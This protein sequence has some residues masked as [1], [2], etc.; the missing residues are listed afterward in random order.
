[1]ASPLH[2]G[3]DLGTTN[4][5]ALVIDERGRSRGEGAC[6]IHL[7]PVGD[8][9]VEQDLEEIWQ[10]TLTAIRAALATVDPRAVAALGIS[11][12]GGAL[13]LLT[14]DQQPLGRVISWLD[15]RG[16]HDDE[17]LTAA[18]GRPWFRERIVHGRCALAPGQLLRLRRERPEWLTPPHRVG[19]VGDAI[20]GRLCGRA[21]HDA[22]S[23]GL[24]LLLNPRR[25]GYDPDLLDQLGLTPEQ[26]P[27]LLPATERAGGLSASVA[28]A[29][30]LRAGLPVSP[31][32]HD[33]YAS[34]LSTGAVE[35]GV[36]MVGA[37]TAWV[38]LA[39]SRGLPP[40][41]MDDAFVCTHVVPGLGGEILSLVNG[42]SALTWVLGLLGRGQ[43]TPAEIEQLLAA[44]PAGCDGLRCWPFLTPFGASGLAPGTRGRFV[45]LQLGHTPAHL[46]RAV[47]EGLACE[48]AR[49]LQFLERAGIPAQ[50]LVLGGT[51]AASPTTTRIIADVTAL[52]LG[53]SGPGGGSVL[54]A[55]ILARALTEP[56]AALADL[57]R[58][59]QPPVRWVNPGPQADAYRAQLERY[60]ATL[61]REIAPAATPMS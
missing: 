44:A 41:V 49:H 2:L 28:A 50:R 6:G 30:G 57:S 26:L 11:S 18:L 15:Q 4:V 13:Q 12:Q 37:G 10:A 32:I 38:L 17:R 29:T 33:Q 9:G 27:D 25:G 46:A 35:P 5:K 42:G 16:R 22:T 36:V 51:V 23:A 24:T 3:L 14:A 8:G 7:T 20:V 59:L 21:A 31:A 39:V 61:P 60:L 54:G 53:C 1:M 43:A 52:P 19:F 34:A 58:A 47:V 40:L 55:A 56:G 48:L 45:D